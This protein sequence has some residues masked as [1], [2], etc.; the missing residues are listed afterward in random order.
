MLRVAKL[1]NK[2]NR[3]RVQSHSLAT[4][5]RYPLLFICSVLQ[6]TNQNTENPGRKSFLELLFKTVRSSLENLS[7][8]LPLCY[9]LLF[10]MT[11]HT[12]WQASWCSPIMSAE[13]WCL[14][15]VWLGKIL[16]LWQSA[17]NTHY[18]SEVCAKSRNERNSLQTWGAE[19]SFVNPCRKQNK[20]NKTVTLKIT[21]HSLS[22]ELVCTICLPLNIFFSVLAEFQGN[23][24]QSLFI[25]QARKGIR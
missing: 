7:S 23:G 16:V 12:P 9:F 19:S 3:A 1:I 18:K 8:T 15:Y 13:V 6:H 2:R 11:V 22:E 10:W 4:L 14:H 24:V 21:F 25:L 5:H 20:L 17:E